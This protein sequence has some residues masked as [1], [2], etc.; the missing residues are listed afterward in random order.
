MVVSARKTLPCGV[1][2]LVVELDGVAIERVTNARALAAATQVSGQLRLPVAREAAAQ[3][4]RL[5]EK[6][7]HIGTGKGGD[8]VVQQLGIKPP[9]RL[10]VSKDQVRGLMPWA[11]LI[12]RRWP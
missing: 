8:A 9:R 10:G 1:K 11:L 12:V 6:A 2:G 3:R 4:Q 5:A 7:Q